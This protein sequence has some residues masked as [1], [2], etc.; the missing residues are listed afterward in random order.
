M[1]KYNF[2]SD[3]RKFTLIKYKF[4]SLGDIKLNENS[5]KFLFII[6]LPRSGTS[7]TEQ[8]L[9]SHENVF[10]G[11]ELPYMEKIFNNYINS[12]KNLDKSDLLKCEKDYVEFTSNL[13]NSNKVLTDK[14]PLNFLYVGFIL[15][16]VA[17]I[18]QYI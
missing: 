6:G 5:R 18:V 13:D 7:L 8:I 9:S 10:G 14:A 3:K 2:E 4:N 12:K 11:G 15:I 16:V 1:S 17:V